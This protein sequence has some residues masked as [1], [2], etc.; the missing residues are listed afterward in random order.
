M[1]NDWYYSWDAGLV[2]YVA[3]STEV[4]FGVHAVGE[5][6]TCSK[7]LEWL[8]ADLAKANANRANIPWIVVHGHRSIYCSCDGK[9]SSSHPRLILTL[10]SSSPH[11]HLILTSSSPRLATGDCDGSA[12]TVRNGTATCGG[13]EEL[14]FEQGVDFFMNGH[15]HDYERNWPTYQVC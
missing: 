11:L 8:K 12:T 7:Q 9:L 5:T 1:E 4:W 14:F 13:L 15:E 3:T 6:D 2:H 10:T